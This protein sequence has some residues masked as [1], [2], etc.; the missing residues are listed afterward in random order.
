MRIRR[1]NLMNVDFRGMDDSFWD[2]VLRQGECWEWQGSFV[3]DGYGGYI[4]VVNGKRRCRQAHRVAYELTHGP[5]PEGLVVCHACDNRKCVRP[6]H[7]F[8][9]TQQDNMRD[10][11]QKGRWRGPAPKLTAQKVIE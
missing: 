8:A 10:M 3:R 5:I 6:S 1:F 11:V 4:S 9:G 2:L 7:L